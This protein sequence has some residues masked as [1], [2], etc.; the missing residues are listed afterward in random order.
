MIEVKTFSTVWDFARE[1]QNILAPIPNLEMFVKDDLIAFSSTIN[2]YNAV[3]VKPDQIRFVCFIIA[4]NHAHQV[5]FACDSRSCI[6][7]NQAKS[8]RNQILE[9]EEKLYQ[10]L[11]YA[12]YQPDPVAEKQ[13]SHFEYVQQF[14]AGQRP[15]R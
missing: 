8:Q 14:K 15:T 7:N 3:L 10:F 11:G 9:L 13:R 2:Y 6:D 4:G 1:V 12:K 5:R